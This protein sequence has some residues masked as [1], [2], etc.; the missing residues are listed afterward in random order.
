MRKRY[1]AKALFLPR[2]CQQGRN[3]IRWMRP[4]DV[5]AAARLECGTA[6]YRLIFTSARFTMT[7]NFCASSSF[8]VLLRYACPLRLRRRIL[9]RYAP[10]LLRHICHY[11]NAHYF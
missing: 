3:E 5:V 2:R 10:I 6:F 4:A 7:L 11:P 8:V 1:A 9:L